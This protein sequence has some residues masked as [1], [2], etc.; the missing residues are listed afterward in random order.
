M[1][2][3]EVRLKSLKSADPSV[4]EK[5]SKFWIRVVNN[6]G[7]IRGVDTVEPFRLVRLPVFDLRLNLN[8]RLKLEITKKS[9]IYRMDSIPNNFEKFLKLPRLAK[10]EFIRSGKANRSLPG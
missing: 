8:F 1:A 7:G 3:K 10:L 2:V 6:F 4:L 5:Q 9:L